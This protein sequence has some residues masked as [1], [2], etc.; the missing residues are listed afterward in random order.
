M[1][2]NLRLRYK[3]SKKIQ[4]R[5]IKNNCTCVLKDRPREKYKT[6]GEEESPWKK[7]DATNL[8]P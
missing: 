7:D 4:G 1:R 3:I 5:I 2:K 8:S 6:I